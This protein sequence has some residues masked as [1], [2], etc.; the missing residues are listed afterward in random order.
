MVKQIIDIDNSRLH[1]EEDFSLLKR[2]ELSALALLTLPEDKAMVDAYKASVQEFDDALVLSRKNSKTESQKEA[3]EAFDALY[4]SSRTY[5]A[6]MAGHPVPEV[7]ESGKI[8]DA[9]Y[10]KYGNIVRYGYDKE[11]ALAYNLMQDLQAL[12][13]ERIE[14]LHFTE[15]VGALSRAYSRFSIAR[16][17]KVFEDTTQITGLTQEKRLAADQAFKQLVMRVNALAI[18]NGEEA[19]A[20]F[21]DLVNEYIEDVL[22]TAKAR[23]TRKANSKEEENKEESGETTDGNATP[24]ETPAG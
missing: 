22:T 20:T 11:Y 12:D 18:V 2:T 4:S 23:A 24:E 3:D 19:Y 13:A 17:E 21:I 7:A 10:E 5:A 16:D 15:W 8:L 6:A 9:I 14:Q 1:T